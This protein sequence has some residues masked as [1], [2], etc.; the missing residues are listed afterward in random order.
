MKL[1]ELFESNATAYMKSITNIDQQERNNYQNFVKTNKLDW[2]QGAVE[3]A[4]KHNRSQDDI[5]GERSR[6]E[7]FIISAKSFDFN[8]FS[9]EDWNDFWLISQHCD[10]NINYQKW[11]LGIIQQHLGEDNQEYKYLC[12]RISCAINHTQKYGTQDEC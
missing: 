6:L 5:F 7:S 1:H 12:D 9:K 3:Y 10:F 4:K 8:N 2:D 11:A